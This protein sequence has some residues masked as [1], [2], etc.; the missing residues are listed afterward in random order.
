M[1][2]RASRRKMRL[3]PLGTGAGLRTEDGFG[4]GD[5]LASA[6]DEDFFAG[7]NA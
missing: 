1:K 6:A 2:D 4:A 7:D 5:V 3:S